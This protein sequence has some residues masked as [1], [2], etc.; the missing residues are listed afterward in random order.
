MFA[1]S[2]VEDYSQYQSLSLTLLQYDHLEFPGVV[3]RTFLG[4]VA[5][6]SFAYPIV[7]FLK[8]TNTSKLWAQLAGNTFNIYLLFIWKYFHEFCFVEFLASHKFLL[9]FSCFLFFLIAVRFCLGLLSLLAFSKFRSSIS[10]RFGKDVG[11]SLA[12]IT[13]TQFHFLFYISRPLPNIFAL[14]LGQNIYSTIVFLQNLHEIF[15]K[16]SMPLSP[17]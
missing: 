15:Q 16:I 3:P 7:T 4:P 17:H 8:A 11:N 10:L 14:I 13:A 6:S 5:V 9:M 2:L 1:L 12:V